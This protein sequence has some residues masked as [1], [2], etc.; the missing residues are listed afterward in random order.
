MTL[1]CY[2]G[3]PCSVTGYRDQEFI[4]LYSHFLLSPTLFIKDRTEGFCAGFVYT[5]PHIR[6]FSVVYSSIMWPT[7]KY[8]FINYSMPMTG[9]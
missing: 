2:A 3:A 7:F 6:A 9:A 5:V 1:P 4:G 8:Y